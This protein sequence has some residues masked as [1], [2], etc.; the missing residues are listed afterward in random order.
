MHDSVVYEVG[1]ATGKVLFEWSALDDNPLTE[2]KTTV[3]PTGR[4]L[5]RSRRR[6]DPYHVNSVTEDGDVR[7][8]SARNTHAVYRVNRKSGRGSIGPS[9]ARTATSR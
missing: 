4:S 6:S 2:S 9:A 3:G 1:V 5:A 8:V 7:L